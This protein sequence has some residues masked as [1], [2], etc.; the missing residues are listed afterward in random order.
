MANR[1]E[2]KMQLLFSTIVLETRFSPV[3]ILADRPTLNPQLRL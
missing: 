1:F 2:G 3:M